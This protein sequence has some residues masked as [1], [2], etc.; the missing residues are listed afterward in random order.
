MMELML[1]AIVVTIQLLV[2][3]LVILVTATLLQVT[4]AM[5]LVSLLLLL[6]TM[7]LLRGSSNTSTRC[8]LLL[9]VNTLL[10][11]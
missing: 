11:V 10:Q 6:V 2:I 4:A 3:W 9:G 7:L 1:V 8:N 5:L